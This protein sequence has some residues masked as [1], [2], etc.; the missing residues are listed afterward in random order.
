M[1]TRFTN[2]LL[3]NLIPAVLVVGSLSYAFMGSDGFL[4]RH[5]LRQQVLATEAAAVDLERQ[6]AATRA[7][8]WRLRNDP[9]AIRR[10][11]AEELLVAEPGSTIYRFVA[12]TR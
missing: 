10:A 7:E 11:A 8:V 6:N 5:D 2:R 12:P 4:Y 1:G 3:W 9:D